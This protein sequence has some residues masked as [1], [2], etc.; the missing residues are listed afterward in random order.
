MTPLLNPI[1]LILELRRLVSEPV[2]NAAAIRALVERHQAMAEY[3]IARFYVARHLTAQVE[4]LFASIDPR[5]RRAGVELMRLGFPRTL[6]GKLL[7][8]VVKDADQG[9]A[10]SARA[11]VRKFGLED[12][13]L[14]DTRYDGARQRIGRWNP[15]GWAFGLFGHQ[16][17]WN[18]KPKKAS[19]I[20]ALGAKGL[21]AITS[22]AELLAFL[23]VDDVTL[24]KLMRPGTA[25]GA[26][27]VE[28]EVPKAKGGTRR[29][30][31]PRGPL[32]KIQRK[33]LDEI[34]AKVPN[35][36]ASHGFVTGRST[37]TNARPHVGAALVVKTDLVEFFPTVHYHRVAGLFGALG[38]NQAIAS[39]LAAITTY[40]PKLADGRVVWPGMLPQG[41]PTSPALANLACRRLD[42]RLA[43][44]AA[45][46]GATYT[47]YADDLTFSF[48]KTPEISI[49]RFFWFVDGVC[50]QE[51]FNEHPG[52]RK[53]LRAKTQQRVT[54][55]VVNEDVHV[56]RRDRRRFRAILH[57]IAKRGLAS[58]AKGR[59]DFAAY[60]QGYA[61]YV[62]MVQPELGKAWAAE[63]AKLL[64]GKA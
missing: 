42:A 43:K 47:R 6:A 11:T 23:G 50:Q 24:K 28:F 25:P 61:A 63:V 10:K 21:P 39:T 3:Q 34:L 51:G 49:G 52:K 14:P 60:L 35:H 44:L 64:G 16:R 57:N 13:A 53:I 48:A 38:Y 56:P 31:A 15:T 5:E 37:V 12:V 62:Q 30:A 20:P 4:A 19:N 7:R 2:A 1:E 54:G 29:L 33:I 36:D 26:A 45:K 32:R 40:R 22:H 58:E 41:A 27:Y 46:F 8:R 18:R 9:V 59:S 55:I 17:S